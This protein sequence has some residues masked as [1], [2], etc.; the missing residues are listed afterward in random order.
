MTEFPT[1]HTLRLTL[2]Q[3]EISDIPVIV[4]YV[5]NPNITNNL[6][7]IPHP[8][9]EKD[10][11]FWLNMV[12]Q[13]FDNQTDYTFRIGLKETKEFIGAMSLHPKKPHHK[14]EAGYW[15][16]EPFWNK[17]YASEALRAVLRF[18]FE[19][20]EL[21][22]IY[23]MYYDYN[24]VSGKVMINNGMIKEAELV[25]NEFKDGKFVTEIQC[26]LTKREYEALNK[27]NNQEKL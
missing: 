26:R 7:N 15:I 11:I 2:G 23:A 8:Y 6:R 5:N 27:K 22:K 21:N 16:G 10:A 9:Y 3:L 17:G 1:L 12:R 18:G 4:K 19:E 24:P 20:L 14:A 13:G 25:D